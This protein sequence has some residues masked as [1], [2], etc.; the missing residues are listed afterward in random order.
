MGRRVVGEIKPPRPSMPKFGF[1]G[2]CLLVGLFTFAIQQGCA[3]TG[4]APSWIWGTLW[5]C[6]AIVLVLLAIW[7]WDRTA[8]HHWVRKLVLTLVAIG[9]IGGLSYIPVAKQ[10]RAEHIQQPSSAKPQESETQQQAP[11]SPTSLGV[12]YLPPLSVTPT[13]LIFKDQYIGAVSDP[14]TVTVTNRGSAPRL[15]S[16]PRTTGDFSQTDDCGP[17]LMTGDS[18]SVDVTFAPKKLG[19]M[20]GSLVI[21]S[22]DPLQSTAY[23]NPAIVT[24]SGSGKEQRKKPPATSAAQNEKPPTLMDLFNKDFSNMGGLTDKG[25]DLRSTDGETIHVNWRVVMDFS[26]K[27]DFVAFYIPSADYGYDSCLALADMVRPMITDLAKRIEVTGGDS[28]GVTSFRDLTFSGRVFIYHEWPLSNK[29]KADITEAYS[30]KG[31]DIQFRGIAYL[32]DQLI[33]WHQK[34]DAKADH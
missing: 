16:P 6:L 19:L 13:K 33:A 20:Y 31:L 28:G 11:S 3:V 23:I 2:F 9:I 26:G 25:F 8:S 27:S 4:N 24:F 1:A 21:A 34:H 30:A 32:G 18:C 14:Q 29:Q 10:Y 7:F 22:S 17:E 15:M 5:F 12:S